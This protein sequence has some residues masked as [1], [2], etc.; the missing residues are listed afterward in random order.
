MKLINLPSFL[1]TFTPIVLISFTSLSISIILLVLLLLAASEATAN[2]E[3]SP[4]FNQRLLDHCDSLLDPTCRYYLPK[5]F[6]FQC[7]KTLLPQEK[8]SRP[9]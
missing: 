6:F 3:S 8:H 4:I 5:T 9:K 1:S 7:K 2:S